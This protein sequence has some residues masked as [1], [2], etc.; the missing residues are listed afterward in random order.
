MLYETNQMIFAFVYPVER[1]SRVL[2]FDRAY[3]VCLDLATLKLI[4][5][6]LYAAE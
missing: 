6:P 2:G 1:G 5:L 3:R 4:S